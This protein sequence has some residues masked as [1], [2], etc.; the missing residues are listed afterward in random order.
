MKHNDDQDVVDPNSHAQPP[1]NMM[2]R[3]VCVCVCI[4][5]QT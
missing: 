5:V 1:T 4:I 2:C 3:N